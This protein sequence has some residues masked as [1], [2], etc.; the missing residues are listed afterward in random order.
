MSS[1]QQYFKLKNPDA[2]IHCAGLVGGIQANIKQPYSF[3]SRNLIQLQI[4]KGAQWK[5][6]GIYA[7]KHNEGDDDRRS[8]PSDKLCNGGNDQ[9]VEKFKL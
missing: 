8:E 3:L 7:R 5:K 2:I 1:A 4:T 9:M 6:L